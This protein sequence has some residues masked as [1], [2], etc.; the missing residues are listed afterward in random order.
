MNILG[1]DFSGAKLAGEKIWAAHATL[2]NDSLQFKSVQ[3]GLAL[4]D[5]EAEREKVFP[6][7]V[8]WISS[9]DDYICGLDFP[10]SLNAENIGDNWHHWLKDQVALYDDADAFRA[11]FSDVR[12]R[13]DIEAKTPFSPLNKRLYRQ[14]FYGLHDVIWPLVQR[15]AQVLPFDAPAD[16]TRQLIEICPASLLK[17]EKFYLSYKGKSASQK[18]NRGIIWD[19]MQRRTDFEAEDA[20]RKVAIADFEGDALDA[21]LSALCVVNSL[22][23]LK[24]KPRDEIEHREGRV[25]F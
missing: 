3:Q 1:V 23:D 12:R 5:S 13:C 17:K 16:S 2:E 11:K 14:T 15:G 21:V 24:I 7:L 19:E 22:S 10:F 8:K 20:F 18:E 25:Y 4:P 9:F 6:A